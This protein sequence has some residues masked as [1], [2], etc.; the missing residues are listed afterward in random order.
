[1]ARGPSRVSYGWH[2]HRAV[3]GRAVDGHSIQC[4]DC[5]GNRRAVCPRTSSA[6]LAKL[7]GEVGVR[8]KVLGRHRWPCSYQYLDACVCLSHGSRM[9]GRGAVC[10]AEAAMVRCSRIRCRTLKAKAGIRTVT[11]SSGQAGLPHGCRGAGHLLKVAHRDL[12]R[13]HLGCLA[14]LCQLD[15]GGLKGAKVPRR[16]GHELRRR[17]RDVSPAQR[18][19]QSQPALL[20]ACLRA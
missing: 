3:A 1:M 19:P 13:L 7:L 14:L 2:V 5:K 4:S 8:D 12:W 20:A 18:Q 11:A 9:L 10:N 17:A 6:L 16:A 15:Q